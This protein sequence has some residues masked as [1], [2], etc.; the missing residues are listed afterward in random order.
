MRRAAILLTMCFAF[1]IAAFA[2]MEMPKPGP[3]HKKLDMFAGSWTMTGDMKPGPMGPG[4]KVTG[5]ESCS[6]MDGNF[7]LECH[8]K[9]DTPMGPGTGTSY[10]GYSSDDKAYTYRAFNSMGNFEDARGNWD[11]ET[12]TW[13]SDEHMGGMTSKG[14]Y[15]MK[16][17]SPT[18]YTYKFEV[19]QDGTTW[20]TVMDGT[21]KKNK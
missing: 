20:N 4:G 13:T 10:M 15:T 3:E 12:L 2:Q 9:Y 8:Q 1:A 6:W 21:A 7:F 5:T 17:V 16:I 19:S 14:R 11:G 18:S